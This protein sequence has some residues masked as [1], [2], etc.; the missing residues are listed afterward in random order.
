[1]PVCVRGTAA[2]S[3]SVFSWNTVRNFVQHLCLAVYL[4]VFIA[5]QNGHT[6]ALEHLL[7]AGAATDAGLTAD[8]AVPLFVAAQNG[9]PGQEAMKPTVTLTGTE[10]YRQ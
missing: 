5:A 7:A 8:G 4:E 3:K 6:A 9:L 2:P 10:H 1:M